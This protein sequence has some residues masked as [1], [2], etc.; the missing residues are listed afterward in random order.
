MA[1]I[2]RGGTDDSRHLVDDPTTTRQPEPNPIG[3][4]DRAA[5]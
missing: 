1:R 3:A 4:D 2:N 5:V